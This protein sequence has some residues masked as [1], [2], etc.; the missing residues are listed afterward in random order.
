MTN[1]V[2]SGCDASDTTQA[3]RGSERRWTGSDRA[4][5]GESYRESIGMFGMVWFGMVCLEWCGL[6][7]VL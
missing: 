4:R 5:E 2:S 7:I 3:T 1:D 6:C